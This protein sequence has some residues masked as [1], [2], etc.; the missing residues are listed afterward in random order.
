[1]RP[2][3][4]KKGICALSYREANLCRRDLC[5]PCSYAWTGSISRRIC[6]QK[7]GGFS[8]H[9]SPKSDRPVSVHGSYWCAA[10]WCISFN[11]GIV[12]I[13]IVKENLPNGNSD[14]HC[15]VFCTRMR[16]YFWWFVLNSSQLQ[17]IWGTTKS[18]M[19][20]SA[21]GTDILITVRDFFLKKVTTIFALKQQRN[22]LLH[23]DL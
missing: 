9:Y 18:H 20:W 22:A 19:T 14:I 2:A 6:D 11:L 7:K 5:G 17:V 12:Q 3:A 1:M 15:K 8:D 16:W 13:E 21:M 10:A 4:D 23:L